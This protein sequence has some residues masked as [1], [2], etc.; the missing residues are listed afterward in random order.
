MIT[1]RTGLLYREGRFNP[2]SREQLTRALHNLLQLAG[3]EQNHYA[4]HSFRI[5]A[6][7]TAA[8]AGLPA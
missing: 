3:Y 4:S 2:L 6:A 8:V 1:V 7:T 5:G